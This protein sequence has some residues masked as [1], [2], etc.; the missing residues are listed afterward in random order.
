MVLPLLYQ[1]CLVG[2]QWRGTCSVFGGG[3]LALIVRRQPARSSRG[4]CQAW[5]Y[6]NGTQN[7]ELYGCNVRGDVG[8]GVVISIG[9]V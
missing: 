6:L 9:R 8:L 3:D 2:G 1:L 7:Q 4:T 5:K